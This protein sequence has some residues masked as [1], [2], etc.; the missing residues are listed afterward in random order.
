MLRV[1]EG[2]KNLDSV[3][4]IV[5]TNSKKTSWNL[6]FSKDTS[7]R[8]HPAEWRHKNTCLQTPNG[9]RLSEGWTLD[10]KEQRSDEML[11][12]AAAFASTFGGL[13]IVG[14]S[15]KDGRPPCMFRDEV[16]EGHAHGRWAGLCAG[17]ATQPPFRT[18]QPVNR[19]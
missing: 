13:L 11:K 14:V 5:A 12:R 6:A 2:F 3:T 7:S 16:S 4:L 18:E 1:L 17:R 8:E 15:E 9:A 10:F 19:P